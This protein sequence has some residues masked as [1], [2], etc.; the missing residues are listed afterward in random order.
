MRKEPTKTARRV[1]GYTLYKIFVDGMKSP[2][3]KDLRWSLPKG[4]KPGD[5]KTVRGEVVMCRNGFHALAGVESVR[6]FM[7][8]HHTKFWSRKGLRIFEV[9]IGMTRSDQ[10]KIEDT[11][12]YSFTSY[13]HIKVCVP[14]MR[15]LREV[16]ARTR[17]RRGW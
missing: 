10:L 7:K 11:G 17:K 16:S 14:S 3:G 2:F 6:Q 9:E 12:D 15:L 4:K 1:V 13:P 5:W 8:R